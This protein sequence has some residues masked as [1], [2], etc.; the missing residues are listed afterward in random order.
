MSWPQNF[1]QSYV[2]HKTGEK[3]VCVFVPERERER[4]RAITKLSLW[5]QSPAQKFII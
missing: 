4:G 3:S 5:K 1:V 2:T